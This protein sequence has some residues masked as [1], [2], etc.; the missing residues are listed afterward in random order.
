[1]GLYASNREMDRV[2]VNWHETD[3][4]KVQRLW[5]IYSKAF[6]LEEDGAVWIGE[7]DT[8]YTF[9]HVRMGY[10]GV[11]GKKERTYTPGRVLIIP[12]FKLNQLWHASRIMASLV[13]TCAFD[14]S[15]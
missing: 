1:M 7:N 8:A 3:R 2:H 15:V 5:K 4:K 13:I 9:V 12:A 6:C 14:M 10:H 11:F